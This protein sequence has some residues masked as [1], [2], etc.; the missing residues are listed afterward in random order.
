MRRHSCRNLL[1][2]LQANRAEAAGLASGA[3]IIWQTKG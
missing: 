1:L 3:V 2:E